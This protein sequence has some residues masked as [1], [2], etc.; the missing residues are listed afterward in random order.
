VNEYGEQVSMFVLRT[1]P[2]KAAVCAKGSVILV[3]ARFVGALCRAGHAVSFEGGGVCEGDKI[4]GGGKGLRRV[5]CI[6]NG[7]VD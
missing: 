4:G 1:L 7:G 5:R 3:V 2:V 6:V